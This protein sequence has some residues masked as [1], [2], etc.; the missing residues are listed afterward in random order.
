MGLDKLA[1][2]LI[3]NADHRTFFDVWMRQQR[4]FDFRPGDIVAGRN[5]HIVGARRK[6]EIAL[7][8]LDKCVAGEIPPAA[9]IGILPLV[10]EIT[11]TGGTTNR[12]LADLA[13]G[14]LL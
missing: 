14:L 7:V 4:R 3:G 13:A 1:A 8:V 10:G 9:H 6:M 12:K 5:D 2:L 11:A